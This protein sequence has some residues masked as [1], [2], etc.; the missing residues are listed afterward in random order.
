MP[1]GKLTGKSFL[2]AAKTLESIAGGA[3]PIEQAPSRQP[4]IE[5][6]T[7]ST[8][9]KEIDNQP[10]TPLSKSD[11]ENI[12]RLA[13]LD[14]QLIVDVAEMPPVASRYVRSREWMTSEFCQEARCGYLPSSAK[15]TLRGHFVYGVFDED[16]EPLAWVGRDVNYDDKLIKWEQSGRQGKEPAKYKFPSKH[17]FRRKFELFGQDQLSRPEWQD[18]LQQY[19]LTITEGFNDVLALRAIGVP[20][21][22]IM[23]NRTTDEQIR[24]IV[25]LANEHANGKA[26]IMFDTD[27]PGDEGAKE[28]LWQLAQTGIDV[29]LMWSREIQRGR[30]REIEAESVDLEKWQALVKVN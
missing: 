30:F 10:N 16:G 5:S 3:A 19:G 25:R 9:E 29:R 26:S 12:R 23:S 22:A 4:A 24:K 14:D 2:E 13:N 8:R 15:G 6:P 28:T 1:S 27:L 21:V 11:N 7:Q 20:S 17:Y 18:P